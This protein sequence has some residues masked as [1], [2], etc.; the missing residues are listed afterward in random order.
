[1]TIGQR[2]RHWLRLHVPW[3][4][5][6]GTS[7]PYLYR[8]L[9]WERW[10]CRIYLHEILRSDEDPEPHNHPWTFISVI[11]RE[12]YVEERNGRKTRKY[13]GMVLLRRADDFHRLELRRPA[14]TLVFRGRERKG[15]GF[16]TA[17]GF[18]DSEEF[19]ARKGLRA[20]PMTTKV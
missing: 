18:M 16:M 13:P 20:E 17:S 6:H 2:L 1:M 10:G 15:W 14:W 12:G 11:L 9:L 5:L 19:L 4:C 3:K 7:G 8:Y